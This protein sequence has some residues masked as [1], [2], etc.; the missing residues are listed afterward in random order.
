MM[1]S[2]Q[3][4]SLAG[5]TLRLALAALALTAALAG[6]AAS[7]AA[8]AEARAQ[9]GETEL[10]YVGTH[11][12]Q[13]HALRFEASTGK[14]AAL[15]PVA[16]GLKPTWAVAHP[17][18]PILYVVDDDKTRGSVIAFSV[19]RASG[20]LTRLAEADTGGSGTTN[21]WLDQPSST[22][23][24]ANFGGGSASSIALKPDGSFGPLVST[25]KASGSGPHRR[26][27]SAH[28]HGVA[29]DPSGRYALVADMG[30]DR[31]FVYGF[32]RETHALL[33]DDSSKPRSFAAPAGSGPRH[34]AFGANGQ[35]V[36]LLS[37]LTAEITVLRW[38]A[39]QAQLTSVQSL[40]TTSL[41]FKGATSG[42]EVA[43]SPDGRFVYVE[44]RGE[45]MLVVY[46]VNAATGELSL[47]QRI[48]SG[49]ELPW[50]FALHPSGKWLLVANERS[51]KVNVFSV[52]M[53]T[54][55]LRDSGAAVDTPAP[56]SITFVQ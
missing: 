12:S 30:A 51:G 15:G 41:E 45:N 17:R 40:D 53:A 11:G 49:G 1:K 9:E 6:S 35:Y 52:D 47:V 31:L 44:N 39:Q 38:D 2:L 21:L 13:L 23:L 29:I 27:A 46:R 43:V 16:E 4:T 32:D 34:L 42:A 33:P 48:A 19:N 50:G 54:G 7:A 5:T 8:N 36:Y 56:V 25:I 22:L 26:Q 14:L 55:R 28:A 37:E 24:T 18:I 10:V 20:A 3:N